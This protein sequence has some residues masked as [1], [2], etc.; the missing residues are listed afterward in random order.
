MKSR[1]DIRL[2]T[3]QDLPTIAD[4][5]AECFAEVGETR[6]SFLAYCTRR[7][8]QTRAAFDSDKIVG[9]A[10][11]VV[12]EGR[13]IYLAWF[14]VTTSFRGCGAGKALY[15]HLYDFAITMKAPAIELTSR[16]RFRNAAHF[17]I[18]CGFETYGLYVGMDQDV[19]LEM[20]ARVS[21][22]S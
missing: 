12:R 13:S 5:H 11:S 10:T 8:V 18:D 1:F 17:Y 14:G 16:N 20:R 3:A 15:K 19:M 22:D 7:D 6:E 4:I 21:H 9:Y 2:A